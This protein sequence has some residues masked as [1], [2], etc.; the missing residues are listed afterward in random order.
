MGYSATLSEI[1]IVISSVVLASGVSGYLVYTGGLLQSDIL[2]AV[3]SARMEMSVQ[4][5]IVYATVDTSTSPSHFVFYAKNVG[6][7]PVSDYT[8]LDVYAG[9]YRE[10]ELYS[11]DPG[12]SPGSHRFKV[13]DVDGDGVWEVG[14]TATIRAYPDSEPTGQILEVRLMPFKGV[15]SNFLFSRP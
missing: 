13:E 4:L 11:Y 6:A 7:L 5:E 12:A 15:G 9:K 1:I 3:E 8:N 10:A 14:E 2:Q